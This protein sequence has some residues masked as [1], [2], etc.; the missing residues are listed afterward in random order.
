MKIKSA[1]ILTALALLAGANRGA[2]Q[3]TAFTYQG[4]LTESGAPA[5][6]LYDLQFI[7]Y[8][9]SRGGSQAGPILTNAATV[10]SNGLFTVTLDFGAGL[11]TGSNEWL[12][13]AARTNG[14]GAFIELSPR[15]EL[16]PT[17]YAIFANTSSNLSGT[18]SAAQLAGTVDD[19]QLTHSAITLMPGRV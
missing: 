4:R 11:F 16:T 2:A 10:V 1:L 7:I 9:A 15:Q 12:D 8:N 5:N 17:P 13:I 18:L 3:G 14:G 6:G 19:T